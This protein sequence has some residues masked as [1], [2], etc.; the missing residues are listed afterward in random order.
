MSLFSVPSPLIHFKSLKHF[1]GD[2][3]FNRLFLDSG[4]VSRPGVSLTYVVLRPTKRGAR[5]L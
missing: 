3:S 1:P 2:L 4:L 5:I